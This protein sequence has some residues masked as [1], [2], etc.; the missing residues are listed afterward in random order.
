MDGWMDGLKV[1]SANNWNYVALRK[2]K[3]N[4]QVFKSAVPFYYTD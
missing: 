4:T 2:E 3:E 1:Y